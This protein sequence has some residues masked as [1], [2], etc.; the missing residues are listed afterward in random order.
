MDIQTIIVFL[1]FVAAAFYIGKLIYNGLKSKN[2]CANG[3]GKC[4][5][6]LSNINPDKN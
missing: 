3:C 5:V 2:G 6:D 4:G 1:L